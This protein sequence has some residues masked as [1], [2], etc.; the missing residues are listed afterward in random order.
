[1]N[2][3]TPSY[4]NIESKLNHLHAF[5]VVASLDVFSELS[6]EIQ[7][8]YYSGICDL[9]SQ[10]KEDFQKLCESNQVSLKIE[11]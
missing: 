2:T 9:A 8:A 10:L 11:E 1:M 7:Q 6:D 4:L 3:D 5:S